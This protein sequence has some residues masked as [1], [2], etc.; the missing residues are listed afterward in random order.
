LLARLKFGGRTQVKTIPV[1]VLRVEYS[2]KMDRFAKWR[3]G[4]ALDEEV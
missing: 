3:R 2:V 1:A 4:D